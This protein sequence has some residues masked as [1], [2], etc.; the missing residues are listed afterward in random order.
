M[1]FNFLLD[2]FNEK[3]IEEYKIFYKKHL[4]AVKNKSEFI[5][6]LYPLCEKFKAKQKAYSF[7]LQENSI[8]KKEADDLIRKHAGQDL[9]TLFNSPPKIQ[10]QEPTKKYKEDDHILWK[11]FIGLG[12]VYTSVNETYKNDWTYQTNFLAYVYSCLYYN[13][14][15][16]NIDK[17]DVDTYKRFNLLVYHKHNTTSQK[18]ASRALIVKEDFHNSFTKL[19]IKQKPLKFGGLLIPFK[20]IDEVKITTTLLKDDELELFAL[21]KGFEWN[22]L[23]KDTLSLIEHCLDETEAYHPNPF[24]ETDYAKGI[25]TIMIQETTQSLIIYPGAYKVYKTALEKFQSGSYERNILD[26]CR[27]SIELVLRELFNN[28]KSL[29]N[30]ISNVGNYQIKRGASPELTNMFV[31]ILDYYSK[32]QNNYVKHEDLVKKD[33]IE[34]ILS[35]SSTFIKYL[36][37]K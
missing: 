25:D 22:N 6:A 20:K 35:L 10:T 33:E 11:I 36:I 30:Q 37:G 8:L 18:V 17:R 2:D 32:Y 34:I 9:A 27:L 14:L 15:H 21:T 4:F 1:Q 24:D 13:G 31:K 19:Y 7:L 5:K 3:P 12:E 26:D 23:K 16:P 29:E 28:K